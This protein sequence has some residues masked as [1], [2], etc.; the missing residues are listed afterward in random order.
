M[1]LVMTTNRSNNKIKRKIKKIRHKTEVAEKLIE[2]LEVT[3]D[4]QLARSLIT[5]VQRWLKRLYIDIKALMYK[6]NEPQ[7]TEAYI[8]AKRIEEDYAKV[9]EISFELELEESVFSE[10]D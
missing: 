5:F 1:S 10:K 8:L 9:Q 4:P 2:L 3:D 6:L 7:K